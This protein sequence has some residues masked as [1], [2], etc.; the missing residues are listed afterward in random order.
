[1]ENQKRLFFY[2]NLI[3]AESYSDHTWNT[4]DS[5]K[6]WQVFSDSQSEFESELVENV[7]R[8]VLECIEL[9]WERRRNERT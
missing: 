9:E 3:L 4:L 7:L 6:K 2:V 1:L 5:E 8:L